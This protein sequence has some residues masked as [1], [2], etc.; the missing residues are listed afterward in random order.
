MADATIAEKLYVT[1]Q[2]RGDANN[3]DG[4]LGFA[5]PYTKDSAFE[6]RKS[7]QDSWA[8]GGATV[9]IDDEDNCT[10]TG[11]GTRGGY[12]GGV[13]W[14]ASMLFIAGCYPRV[15]PND[16]VAGFEIAKSVR[17]SGWNGSGNVKWRITDPRGFDLEIS[18]ENFARVLACS[19]LVNG[20]IQ[21]NCVWGRIGKDNVLLPE[22]S[23]PYQKATEHTTKVNTKIS[24]KDLNI[25]DKVE[26]L[27]TKVREKDKVCFYMGKYF[28]L[29]VEEGV[30]DRDRNRYSYGTGVFYFNKKQADKYLFKSADGGQYF[31][32]ASPKVVVIH[33]KI[34]TPLNKLEVARTVTAEL[35]R[36]VDIDD[37]NSAIL[38]SPTKIDLSTV[39]SAL[40]PLGEK[41]TGEFPKV[42]SYYID[43]IVV[44]YNDKM[45][46]ASRSGH[47]KYNDVTRVYDYDPTLVEIEEQLVDNKVKIK[48]ITSYTN[49]GYGYGRTERHERIIT[50]DFKFED[51]EL[52]RIVTAN[53][54]AGKV[55]RGI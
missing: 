49:P 41:I 14:D 40:M 28:F 46:L 20:V 45:Y 22:A 55:Y 29:E 27:S 16:P 18:S 37:V 21:G 12:G 48:H 51:L 38:V 11:G 54:I 50:T 34:P 1:V 25:G 53:D 31:T 39:T 52:F 6:K 44:K 10:V 7:T 3:T 30:T 35:S 5:S 13:K 26:L 17:R 47:G 2:Y 36:T 33:D 4:L 23:E 43:P 32:L 42:G 15:I 19:T 8:Y 9:T 24:L